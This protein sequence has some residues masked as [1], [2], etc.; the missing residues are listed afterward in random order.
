MPMLGLGALAS[1]RDFHVGSLLVS[2]SRRFIE[3]PAGSA[4]LQPQAMLVFFCLAQ[5]EGQVVPR[6]LLFDRCWGAAPVGD[7]SINQA[8]SS[9]RHALMSVG[10]DGLT[11]ETVPRSGYR[12][13]ATTPGAA[14]PS[15]DYPP[16]VQRAYDCWRLGWPR[17][18]VTEIAALADFL[19]DKPSDA[20]GWGVL[21]LLLRKAAEY[22]SAADC[23]E[24]VSRCEGAARHALRRDPQEPTARV[25]LTG[26]TPLFGNWMAAR[27]ELSEVLESF[28]DHAP[29]L[30]DFLFLE[31]ATG[32]PSV[33][34]PITEQL[35]AEDHFAATYHYKAMY[36]LW[37]VGRLH[38]AEQM[39]ARAMALWPRHPANW[40]ARFWTLVGTS[41]AD[42]ALRLIADEDCRP[43]LPSATLASLERTAM[44][45]AAREAG[46][47]V[48]DDVIAHAAKAVEIASFGPAN[49]V[50]SL[51]TLCVLN[52]IDQAFEVAHG[53]YLGQGSAAVPLR[54]NVAD[55]SVTDQYR[56]VTQL[57]FIPL[58]ARMREDP[59]FL[60]LCDEIGLS[61][62]WDH[63][64]ITPDFLAPSHS[65]HA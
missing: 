17:P 9:V 20:G 65:L 64:G 18:D 2:P 58:A 6:H 29:A 33:A 50:A 27:A 7:D 16:A 35:L 8:I 4:H 25:A 37:T 43:T 63:H 31:M 56:R 46:G 60:T 22:A 54:W 36:Q 45:I 11:I 59:R 5:H 23:A 62:Y 49:A 34:L 3:G 48:D 14:H 21:A 12:L 28:P 10:A 15:Q 1:A 52:A 53:Y 13:V 40:L 61:A 19:T 55:P 47:T 57:L 51:Q 41:R 30:H 32:R 42:Q 44:L 38:E 39:A 24:F 26:L